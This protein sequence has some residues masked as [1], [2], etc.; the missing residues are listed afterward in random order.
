MY[1]C[2]ESADD[3]PEARGAWPIRQVQWHDGRAAAGGAASQQSIHGQARHK[4]ADVAEC[5]RGSGHASVQEPGG[6]LVAHVPVS[7]SSTSLEL[8]VFH[9][10]TFDFFL[11][12]LV[13]E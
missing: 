10:L 13:I 6:F 11:N 12:D 2:R 1:C 9:G 7:Q 8:R 5:G 4:A 3:D